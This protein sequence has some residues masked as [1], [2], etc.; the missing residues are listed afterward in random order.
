MNIEI[1]LIFILKHY[2]KLGL[3]HFLINIKTLV[4]QL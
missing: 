4:F 3:T 2:I 1:I